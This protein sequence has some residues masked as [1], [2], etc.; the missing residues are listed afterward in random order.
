MP[1]QSLTFTDLSV[2]E[3][4][5][6]DS[7]NYFGSGINLDSNAIDDTTGNPS[8]IAFQNIIITNCHVNR[9]FGNG[10]ITIYIGDDV[11]IKNTQA[12]D[13]FTTVEFDLH[14]NFSGTY[15]Y[16]LICNNLQMFKCQGNGASNV[17]PVG[18]I[19]GGASIE[20][21]VNVYV[22]ECQF[23][24]TFG[25]NVEIA[26]GANL[27]ENQ[28][29]LY[30]NCQFNNTRGGDGVVYV[31]GVHMSDNNLDQTE[32]NG[33]KFLNCQFNG[34]RISPTNGVSNQV[35]GTFIFTSRN[36]V[37]EN[38]QATNIINDSFS[39][40]FG[41]GIGTNSE[42]TLPEFSSGR[43]IT[44]LNCIASDIESNRRAIGI[45]L[46]GTADNNS[47][48]EASLINMVVENCISERIHSTSRLLKWPVLWK[49]KE[50]M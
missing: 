37:F 39:D 41:F 11:I 50:A 46:F 16:N 6:P 8:Q 38:C 40:A 9:C 7:P 17:D 21:C 36:I 15:G 29:A 19:V 48:Q 35:S 28:N 43:N 13:L 42:S 10:S 45:R 2:L 23:N 4:G 20:N 44:F 1:F 32:A 25:D 34:L 33:V 12:N 26:C 27:E 3:C 24:D 18:F 30:E 31:N 5:I 49:V 47:G 14:P 22:K